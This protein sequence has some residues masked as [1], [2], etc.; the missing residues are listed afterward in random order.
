MRILHVATSDGGG[1]GRAAYR[2]HQGL[3]RLGHDSR[4]MVRTRVNEDETV[5]PWHPLHA[6]ISAALGRRLECLI[7]HLGRAE[8][9]PWWVGL[10]PGFLPTTIHRLEPD[11]VHLHWVCNGFLGVGEVASI[12]APLVWSF[13]DLGVL[14]EGYAYLDSMLPAWCAE[15]F[16]QKIDGRSRSR[17]GHWCWDRRKRL[18]AGKEIHA[19][20]PSRWMAESAAASELFQNRRISHIPY[21]LDTEVFRPQD[22]TALRRELGLPLESR[23]ILF[24]AAN[25]DG[26]PRKGGDLLIEALSCLRHA[27]TAESV[28][29]VVF[30][31]ERDGPSTVH[32]F[33]CHRLGNLSDDRKLSSV[34]AAC[35]VFIAPSREDNLPNTVLE[36]LACGTPVV[37]FAIGGMPDMILPGK[38][39][40]LAEPF[41]GESIASAIRQALEDSDGCLSEGARN[42]ALKSYALEIQ[43]RRMETL[44]SEELARR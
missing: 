11:I 32:D 19:V 28:E 9:A 26:D 43:A 18:W 1:A 27:G 44:Y 23:L 22:K 13:H 17:F 31:G 5:I 35:D 20:A 42:H 40:Y 6:R 21:G 29:V 33:K 14:T 25:A 30:G 3:L 16:P 7:G 4:M 34:Y 12:K 2:L 15:G 37:A 38:T 39:G 8:D 10:M 24:G 36:S 41:S